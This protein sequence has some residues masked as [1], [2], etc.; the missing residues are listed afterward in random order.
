MSSR[1]FG[2]SVNPC[3]RRINYPKFS[4][5]RVEGSVEPPPDVTIAPGPGVET[6]DSVCQTYYNDKSLASASEECK[7]C[8]QSAL[9][10]DAGC[11]CNYDPADP[12]GFARCVS[13]EF[14][15]PI[16]KCANA[17]A[18]LFN[19]DDV[20]DANFKPPFVLGELKDCATK[21]GWWLFGEKSP[22]GATVAIG[23]AL[24]LLFVIIAYSA[25]S[26]VR[27]YFDNPNILADF[28]VRLNVYVIK[29]LWRFVLFLLCALGVAFAYIYFAC[30]TCASST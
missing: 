20:N 15:K 10:S 19:M 25:F 17:Y 29:G 12:C 27:M 14:K 2:K 21:E 6:E 5:Q 26:L 18:A 28:N 23:L 22:S 1:S 24:F 13:T 3:G 9:D 16:S 30:G 7:A 4:A 11:P 8:W